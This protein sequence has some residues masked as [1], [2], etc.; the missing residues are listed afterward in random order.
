MERMILSHDRHD[1]IYWTSWSLELE[2]SKDTI[3]REEIPGSELGFTQSIER[4]SDIERSSDE[5]RRLIIELAREIAV[6]RGTSETIV[7]NIGIGTTVLC[8][9][10]EFL[11]AFCLVRVLATLL[12]PVSLG[13]CR[14]LYMRQ[15]ELLTD[16]LWS[17]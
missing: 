2:F 17:H 10:P 3:G 5:V 9:I 7:R 13:G 1:T 12:F 16:R 8:T 6:D 4:I 14:L 11:T 15:S